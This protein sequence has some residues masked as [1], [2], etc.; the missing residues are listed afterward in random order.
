MS[1][2]TLT[3]NQKMKCCNR[4]I[5]PYIHK[6]KKA[7]CHLLKKL[8]NFTHGINGYS[9][10]WK[11]NKQLTEAGEE[12]PLLFFPQSTGQFVCH[13][14]YCKLL[15]RVILKGV[16]EIVSGYSSIIIVS[17]RLQR[18]R[19]S[20]ALP[21]ETNQEKF[22]ELEFNFGKCCNFTFYHI[23]G[24]ILISFSWIS[25]KLCWSTATTL[26]WEKEW[27][28]S[29]HSFPLDTILFSLQSTISFALLSL[30]VES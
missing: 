30:G 8:W 11:L 25:S 12:C 26:G 18:T 10:R 15:Q 5:W 7:R 22:Q 29:F 9:K 24:K 23:I 16:S 17:F 4:K 28:W 3:I 2:R 1:C 13:L 6:P 27:S 21:G 20:V 14:F 19:L